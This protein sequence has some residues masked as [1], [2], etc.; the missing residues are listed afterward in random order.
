MHS[1]GSIYTFYEIHTIVSRCAIFTACETTIQKGKREQAS[2]RPFYAWN[3]FLFY[4]DTFISI[5]TEFTQCIFATKILTS[6]CWSVNKLESQHCVFAYVWTKHY[7][8]QQPVKCWSDPRLIGLAQHLLAGN[9]VTNWNN[10]P[11]LE[12]F[13]SSYM[14]M[15]RYLYG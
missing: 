6:R 7:W 8:K 2:V 12:D 4:L 3:L 15:I 5:G 14:K 1:I 9:R 11:V 13:P 10:L